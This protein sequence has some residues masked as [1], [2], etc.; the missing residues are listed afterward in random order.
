MRA[1]GDYSPHL[2]NEPGTMDPL[3]QGREVRLVEGTWKGLSPQPIPCPSLKLAT[4][5]ALIRDLRE[6]LGWRWGCACHLCLSSGDG[7]PQGHLP[8]ASSLPT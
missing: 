7:C 5:P 6:P 2:E 8:R 1:Y 4:L 3:G